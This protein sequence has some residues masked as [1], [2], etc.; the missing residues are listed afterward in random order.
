MRSYQQQNQFLSSEETEYERQIR[1]ASGTFGQLDINKSSVAN[2]KLPLSYPLDYRDETEFR[3]PP[4]PATK[5]PSYLY[6][7]PLPP[8]KPLEFSEEQE[9]FEN[10]P[11]RKHIDASF[12]QSQHDLIAT[13]VAELKGKF[14]QRQPQSA[15]IPP[16]PLVK[17]WQ[18][19]QAI[20]NW[21]PLTERSTFPKQVSFRSYRERSSASMAVGLL[22]NI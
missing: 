22:G 17:S 13:N 4:K 12:D 6:E 3:I 11:V 14:D 10:K 5:P 15:S 2:G 20:P 18:K 7:T 19:P 9:V 8:H 1:M 16:K 21:E